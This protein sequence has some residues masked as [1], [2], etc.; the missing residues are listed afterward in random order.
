MKASSFIFLCCVTLISFDCC[1]KKS[2]NQIAELSIPI[3]SPGVAIQIDSFPL[4]IGNQWT[5]KVVE[6]PTVKSVLQNPD[7]FTF[8]ITVVADTYL[9]NI[10]FVKIEGSSTNPCSFLSVY[11]NHQ[12]N[13]TYYYANLSQGLYQFASLDNIDTAHILDSAQH[14]LLLPISSSNASW[15]SNEP[16]EYYGGGGPTCY[17]QYSGFVN[18]TTPAGNFNTIKLHEDDVAEGADQYF[19]SKGLIQQIQYVVTSYGYKYSNVSGYTRRITLVSVN[20]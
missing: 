18:V 15:K 9:Y 6:Q 5:Y 11:M 3:D 12:S 20:F 14:V 7:S 8:T 4:K 2:T 17:R 1:K 13:G 16:D 19:S 10:R